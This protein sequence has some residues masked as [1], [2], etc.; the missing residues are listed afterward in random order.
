MVF[1]YTKYNIKENKKLKKDVYFLN[2]NN[3][4]KI[5][6]LAIPRS[7]LKYTNKRF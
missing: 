1:N 5:Y 2:N 7:I 3:R 4:N 6:N